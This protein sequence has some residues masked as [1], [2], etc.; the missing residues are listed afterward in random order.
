MNAYLFKL[1]VMETFGDT[2]KLTG[3]CIEFG[4]ANVPFPLFPF[5]DYK[6]E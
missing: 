1:I 3:R 2:R 4:K 5:I 6:L